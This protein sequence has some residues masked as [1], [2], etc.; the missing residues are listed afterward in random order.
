M[1]GKSSHCRRLCARSA[2]IGHERAG[3][4][5]TDPGDGGA[6]GWRSKGSLAVGIASLLADAGHEIPTALLPSLL[7]STL[8]APAAAL[9]TI[10]GVAD[11][12][13]GVARLAGGAI[14]DDPIR[15]RTAAVGGYTATAVLSAAIGAAGSALQVGVLRAGTWAAR[16]L[17]VPA[18]NALLADAV[19]AHAYGR[20]YGFERAMD[21]VGAIVGPLLALAL[22]TLVGVRTAM[23]LSVIPGLLAAAAIVYAI[24]QIPRHRNGQRATLRLRVRPVLASPVRRLAPGIG[25]F[26]LG[27]VAAT[28]LILRASELLSPSQGVE[29]ASSRALALYLAYNVA[30]AATS[31]PAGLVSDRRGGVGVLAAGAGLFTLAYT[32]LAI[33]GPNLSAL[34]GCFSL[35]GIA[36][37]CVETAQHSAVATHAPSEVRG[38]AF[39]LLAATQA[40]GNLVASSIAGLLWTVL[41]PAVAFG[42]AALLSAAAL[43]ALLPAVRDPSD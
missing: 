10:E 33:T 39:G 27:N 2:E 19:P 43:T 15:R 25:L 8:G 11:G 16:G 17:R 14:A 23:L 40:F 37:G 36:I 1:T 9:G 38:S 7:T 35:A 3:A 28:M 21:N 24:R 4:T 20:A 18:R 22:V 6:A 41:S 13:A 32:G 5:T 31:L 29:A 34:L 30:A 42:Y 26:E 12:L